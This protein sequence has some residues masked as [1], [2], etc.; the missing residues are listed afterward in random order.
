M[1]FEMIKS[2]RTL[3][4]KNQRKVKEYNSHDS[5][6]RRQNVKNEFLF[7][8]KNKRV[9]H[10][11]YLSTLVLHDRWRRRRTGGSVYD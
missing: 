3:S 6:Q 8:I 11:P 1:H 2:L 10:A 5:K 7:K 9:L 4:K